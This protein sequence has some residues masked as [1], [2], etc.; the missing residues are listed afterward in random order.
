MKQLV[1]INLLSKV[2]I[3]I[4]SQEAILINIHVASFHFI[5]VIN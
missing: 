2:V 3:A 4:Q 1:A 5:E